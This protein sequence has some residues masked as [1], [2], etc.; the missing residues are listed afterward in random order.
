MSKKISLS[1]QLNFNVELGASA[2]DK[3]NKKVSFIL[4]DETIVGRGWFDM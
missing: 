4:S 2:I 3:E 1:Q